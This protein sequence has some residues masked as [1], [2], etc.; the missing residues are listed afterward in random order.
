MV[1]EQSMLTQAQH[2]TAKAKPADLYRLQQHHDT[3]ARLHRSEYEMSGNS[4]FTVSRRSRAFARPA[5]A[6]QLASGLKRIVAPLLPP[7]LESLSYVPAACH[8]RRT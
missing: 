3:P 4:F 7:V 2:L 5:L 6:P 1:S 8:A